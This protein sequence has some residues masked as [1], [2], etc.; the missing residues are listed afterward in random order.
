MLPLIRESLRICASRCQS[1]ELSPYSE[2]NPKGPVRIHEVNVWINVVSKFS[3]CSGFGF[4]LR[5]ARI[6]MLASVSAREGRLGSFNKD[7]E[8]GRGGM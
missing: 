2:G 3:L 1:Y 7:L 4:F 8:G 5:G 6:L